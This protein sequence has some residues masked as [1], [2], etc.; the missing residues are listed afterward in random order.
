VLLCG[1]GAYTGTVPPPERAQIKSIGIIAAIGDTCMFERIHRGLADAVNPPQ[2]SFLEISDW[3]LDD[4]VAQLTS[5]LLGKRLQMQTITFE[6]QDFD[7]W[8]YARLARHIR[9]LPEPETPIDA[10][11]LILRDWR[12]DEIGHSDSE[13]AGMGVYQS[14]GGPAFRLG[15]FAAYRLVLLDARDGSLMATRSALSPSGKL[16]WMPAQRLLWPH[17][18]ND[19]SPAQGTMLQADFTRLIDQSLP[20]TLEQVL[21]APARQLN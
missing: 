8:T 3:G 1:A 16:P 7:T 6:H 4:H 5:T 14:D 20:R 21:P 15:V 17:T 12:A 13:L 2:A 11:L 19:L 9:E 10:Y 18:Q